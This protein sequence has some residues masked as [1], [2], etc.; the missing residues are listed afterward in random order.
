M[1][2]E[3]LKMVIEAGQKQL[4]LME[5]LR[6]DFIATS[7]TLAA[8][9]EAVAL[10]HPDPKQLKQAWDTQISEVRAGA[11]VVFQG[12]TP[13]ADETKLHIDVILRDRV[14]RG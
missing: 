8:F 4:D 14:K 5:D 2:T 12:D 7:A 6:R 10:T 11:G 3:Q 1:N 9:A 13:C